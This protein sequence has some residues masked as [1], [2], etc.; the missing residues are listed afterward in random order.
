VLHGPAKGR[1][2]KC[3]RFYSQYAAT[4]AAYEATLGAPPPETIWPDAHK[5]FISDPLGVRVNLSDGIFL[6]RRVALALGLT[7]LMVGWLA[8]RIM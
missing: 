6:P 7:L 5:R 1:T 4:L 2:A 3:Q 8:G